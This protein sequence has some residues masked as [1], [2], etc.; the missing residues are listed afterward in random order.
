MRVI[1]SILFVVVLATSLSIT[2]GCANKSTGADSDS[3]SVHMANILSRNVCVYVDNIFLTITGASSNALFKVRKNAALK[4]RA[5]HFS[6]FDYD[7]FNIVYTGFDTIDC[8]NYDTI[9]RSNI[10]WTVGW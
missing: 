4:A 3:V 6:N 10:A 5:Y 9:V 2:T 7:T 8:K 1:N